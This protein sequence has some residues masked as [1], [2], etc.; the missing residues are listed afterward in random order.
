MMGSPEN[1]PERANWEDH[2]PVQL[3]KG[4]WLADTTV[5]QS[6]WKVIT[7]ESPAR[8]TGDN[9]PIENVSWLDIQ[10]FL[11][12]LNQQLG[13]PEQGQVL[14]LPSEAEWEHACRAGTETPFSFGENITPNQVNYDGNYPYNNGKKGE[15]R[16]RTVTVKSLPANA[17]GLYEMHGNVW[18]W[19]ADAWQQHQGKDKQIDPFFEGESSANRVVRGGSWFNDGRIVRSAF[20]H[21]YSPGFRDSRIGFRLLLGNEL[22]SRSKEG[23]G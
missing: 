4:Y 22:R 2:H 15:Y 8:F 21:H 11:K 10:D 17:W 1:E 18:E 6:V 14:R 5:T 16:E 7:G 12:A 9:N 3:S 13:F 20:R 23:A 19:C